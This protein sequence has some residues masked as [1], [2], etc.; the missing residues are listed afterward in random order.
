MAGLR[1]KTC[2][3]A[4][5]TFRTVLFGAVM[6]IW[7][8]SGQT[9]TFK[10][11]PSWLGLFHCMESDTITMKI[12]YAALNIK[13]MTFFRIFCPNWLRNEVEIG[14]FS[15]QR[16]YLTKKS[17]VQVGRA[18]KCIKCKKSAFLN[19]VSGT[20]TISDLKQKGLITQNLDNAGKKFPSHRKLSSFSNSSLQTDLKYLPL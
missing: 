19:Y 13:I 4:T 15:R 8:V 10:G 5:Q 16:G 3:V 17:D 1:F 7:P 14:E 11:H 9:T 12:P 6:F 20:L 18:Q 2:T